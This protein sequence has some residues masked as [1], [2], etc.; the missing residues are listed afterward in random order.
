MKSACFIRNT[1]RFIPAL[2]LAGITVSSPLARGQET[3][4]PAKAPKT[5]PKPEPSPVPKQDAKNFNPT[6]EQLAEGTIVAQGGRGAL[7]QIRRNGIERGRLSRVTD[8]GLAEEGRY[9]LR[10]VRGEST[11]KDKVR[12]DRKTAQAE[13]SLI[14]GGSGQI[15]GVIN[16]AP[17]IPRAEATADFLSDR[18]HSIDALLRYK[19]N[20]SKLNLVGKDKQQGL[21]LYVLELTDKDNQR[22][23]Y[24][25]SAKTLRILRLEYE[26]TAPGSSKTVKYAKRFHDY[27]VAQG[28]LVPY[29]TTLVVDGKLTLE[30][31]ILTVTYGVRMEDALFQNPNQAAASNP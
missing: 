30:T 21:D 31:R 25:I 18:T 15:F 1:L 14:Y 29:R 26:E 8:A 27:R 3:K 7:N 16:G 5:Q 24:Y 6:A 12:L 10:F 19:E 22:T 20:E 9:E 4:P 11:A 13:Y 17:F 2:V 23:R 28:T